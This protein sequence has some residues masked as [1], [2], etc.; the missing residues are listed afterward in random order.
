[1]AQIADSQEKNRSDRQTYLI[2]GAAMEVLAAFL[3]F[4]EVLVELKA[5]N[6]LTDR[7]ASQ[8]I[9]YVAASRLGRGLLLNFGASS[10]QFKRFVGP[11][12]STSSSSVQSVESVGKLS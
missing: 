3:C 7:D 2:I 4:G 8:V 1:M 12:A 10:L 11:S 6:R 5:M 9:N